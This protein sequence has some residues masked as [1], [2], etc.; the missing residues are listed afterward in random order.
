MSEGAENISLA[1]AAVNGRANR[2][3][4][5]RLART[6]A[7]LIGVLILISLVAIAVGSEHVGLNSIL[8][9]CWSLITGHPASAPTEQVSIIAGVRLPRILTAIVVGAALSVAGAAYQGLSRTRSPIPIYS[10]SLRGRQSA[11]L[12]PRYLPS[13]SSW[14]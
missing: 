5:G 4:V 6:M 14:E 13:R 9:I 1:I 12:L 10:E 2:L 3:T 7:I 11:L 8:S